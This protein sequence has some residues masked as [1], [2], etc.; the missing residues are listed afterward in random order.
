MIT[1]I[2]KRE[3]RTQFNFNCFFGKFSCILGKAGM[4]NLINTARK[5]KLEFFL[6]EKEEA[7][8]LHFHLEVLVGVLN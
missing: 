5:Q 2:E 7:R 3:P 6:P 4:F 8:M 1:L